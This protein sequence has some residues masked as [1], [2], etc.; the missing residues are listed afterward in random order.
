MENGP[1]SPMTKP[2]RIK[3]KIQV[4]GDDKNK[5]KWGELQNGPNIA[6]RP[7]SEVMAINLESPETKMKKKDW[8]YGESD[9]RQ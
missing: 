5:E 4:R 9:L 2:K 1:K 6:E 3:W 8:P 7:A